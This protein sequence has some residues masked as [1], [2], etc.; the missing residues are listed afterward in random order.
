MSTP[1]HPQTGQFTGDQDST[2]DT[3]ANLAG[4]LPTHDTELMVSHEGQPSVA[5]QNLTHGAP[6]PEVDN[7]TTPG[8]VVGATPGQVI[9]GPVP[10]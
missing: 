3:W 5:T 4:S 9:G 1:R 2:P 6:A 7:G 10:A 8:Q